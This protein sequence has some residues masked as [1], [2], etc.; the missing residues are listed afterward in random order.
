MIG[1][2]IQDLLIAAWLGAPPACR[3]DWEGARV[4][5]FIGH[6]D[7]PVWMFDDCCVTTDTLVGGL[8]P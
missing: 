5:L 2:F 1:D 4:H 7:T 6:P 8:Q 3:S